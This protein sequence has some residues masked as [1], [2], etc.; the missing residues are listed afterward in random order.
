M[1][2]SPS[3]QPRTQPQQQQQ[4]L[5]PPAGPATGEPPTDVGGSQLSP[6]PATPPSH[7]PPAAGGKGGVAESVFGTAHIVAKC[8]ALG[9]K[10]L[11]SS[12]FRRHRTRRRRPVEGD[13]LPSNVLF[14]WLFRTCLGFQAFVWLRVRHHSISSCAGSFRVLSA[15]ISSCITASVAPAGSAPADWCACLPVQSSFA[16]AMQVLLLLATLAAT[17]LAAPALVAHCARRVLSA[18]PAEA[19]ATEEPGMSMPRK[20]SA[21]KPETKSGEQD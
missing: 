2:F 4:Q 14:R 16:A 13:T 10:T 9:V 1:Q 17:F 6:M 21:K 20:G 8:V 15:P 12:S 11:Q 19:T 5:Q 3:K 7:L 18:S